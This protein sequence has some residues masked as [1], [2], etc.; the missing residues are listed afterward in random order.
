M[1]SVIADYP[2][3][4]ISRAPALKQTRLGQTAESEQKLRKLIARIKAS[5]GDG[6]GKDGTMSSS[7]GGK[8]KAKMG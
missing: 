1:I 7:Q 6:H 8:G 4:L 5:S 2:D 3:P